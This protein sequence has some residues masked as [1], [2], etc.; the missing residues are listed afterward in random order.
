MPRRTDIQSILVIG[1]GPIVIG[2]ACEFDYS[3]TQAVKA[4]KQEG[5]RVILINSNPATIMTDPGLADRTYVEP[6]TPETIEK[7]IAREKPDA[8]LPTVGGQTAL[9][10]AVALAERGILDKYGVRLIGANLTAIKKGEDRDLFRQAMT[11]IGLECPRSNVCH[12]LEEAEAAVKQT[13]IPAVVR[14]AFTLGGTGGGIA[15]NIEEFRELA[16]W[17]LSQS[18]T[19][20]ILVEESVLG[21]KE[22][23]LEVVRDLKDNVVIVCSIENLDPMGVHTGDSITV[24]PAQTLTDREYQRLR[25]AAIRIIREIGVDTGGSNIQFAISPFDGRILVI[26][27][28][29]RVSRSSALASKATGFPIAKIAAKL[30]VGYSLD[31]LTNDITGTTPASFE[32]SIDYVVTK[33]PRFAFEK[34]PGAVDELTTQMKSVG[35][36]MSIGRTFRESLQ[37]GLRSLEIGTHGF[38]LR[39]ADLDD[40]SLLAEVRRANSRRIW[41]LA[42][43]LRRGYILEKIH[44]LTKIDRWF[45]THIQIIVQTERAA[46]DFVRSL[47]G[48]ASLNATEKA[49]LLRL[50]QEGF[51]D[52][53][54]AK[55][56]G[57]T[58]AAL[59]ALREQAGV[60]PK[61]RY[62]D[63]C[64]GEFEAGT[65]YMYSSYDIGG[66]LNP[67]TITPGKSVVILGGG[68]NRIGQGIEFDY[69]C[70]HAC[71]AIKDRGYDAVMINCNPETVST[72]YDT[73]SRLYFEPLTEEDVFAILDQEQ[74]LGVILQFGG[75]TP[76]KLAQALKARGVPILGTSPDA[77]DEAE[78]RDLFNK[79]CDKLGIR[80]PPSGIARSTDEALAVVARIGYP[81]VVRPSFVLG[82]RAMEIVHSDAELRR[83]MREA[84][85]ASEEH[86][87][88]V[89]HYL[90]GA[91]ELDVDVIYDGETMYLGG[92]MQHIEEAGIHSGDSACILPPVDLSAEQIAEVTDWSQRLAKALNVKGCMNVQY[93]IKDG[94]LYILEVNPR[95]S[96]TVPFVSKA[97]GAALA[98]IATE[99][100]L[101]AKLKDMQLPSAFPR[102]YSVK[103]TIFPFKK[104]PGVDTRLGPE[105]RSTG[106]VMGIAPSVSEAF[107]KAQDAVHNT[108]P[109]SGMAL[110]SVNDRDKQAILPA[111]KNL[112]ASG[113]TICAT[114][115]T[116]SFLQ[117]QGIACQVVKKLSEGRPNTIDAVKDGGVTL[118]LN[119]PYGSSAHR[120]ANGLR[121]TALT[122]AVPYFTTIPG[123]LAAA[124]A[125]YDYKHGA[126]AVVCL[127]DLPGLR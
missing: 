105:M 113:F 31:E 122:S 55:L 60:K 100:M 81:V 38:D 5:F 84:V 69:C 91:M 26:E 120:D 102:Y 86:P 53:Y 7:I 111:I 90:D 118:V 32:P 56:G 8:I 14:P 89:D 25:D 22:Y 119:T 125:I 101:G 83:Y 79:L 67:R 33:I 104:F 1:A 82:G 80:Q 73:S 9:N 121:R 110:V 51:S 74:P 64:A 21:W 114:S 99:V 27:M 36:I 106:E 49:E 127:Q 65:P 124:K 10:A 58:Q 45:L 18:P 72:D 44:D 4:L 123:A 29:P 66:E 117:Q 92:I 20:E 43:A 97:T 13:G 96:R 107:W 6:I 103:E 54:L 94:L 71:Y 70:V 23:E 63:T 17:G 47:A 19:T 78:D 85:Q 112:I 46:G 115:G 57:T 52:A 50:K 39:F 87:V 48:K 108:L 30:A 61:F 76:L 28:N 37:K 24:A 41:A 68:P 16:A 88:L 40:D 95:A 109:L 62:V 93:A 35:E 77:I 34:F 2:Q 98:R 42:E 3:G 126:H 116:A 15:Y 11:R 59:R 75:Q 12:T